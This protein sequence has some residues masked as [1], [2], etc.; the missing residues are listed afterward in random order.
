MI[1]TI[2]LS[3][4]VSGLNAHMS[5][6]PLH[7]STFEDTQQ[8]QMQSEVQGSKRGRQGLG[9][10]GL[11]EGVCLQVND[12]LKQALDGSQ[13]LLGTHHQ[14]STNVFITLLALCSG[15]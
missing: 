12:E 2:T 13:L 11:L 6:Q 15:L 4:S 3:R 7:S 10:R 9:W 8:L 14:V 5:T 1:S